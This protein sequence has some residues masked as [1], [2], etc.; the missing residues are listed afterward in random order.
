MLNYSISES[1]G[2]K[3]IPRKSLK[4]VGLKTKGRKI[5]SDQFIQQQ[6][7]IIFRV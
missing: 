3:S 5:S 2:G 4:L 7:E 1:S 6:E